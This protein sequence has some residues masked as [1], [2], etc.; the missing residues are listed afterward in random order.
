MTKISL[1][2]CLK[3]GIGLGFAGALG[4]T[5]LEALYLL[6]GPKRAFFNSPSEVILCLIFLVGLIPLWGV[7]IGLIEG[8]V[9]RLIFLIP[10]GKGRLNIPAL[11]LALLYSLTLFA[12]EIYRN[13][14][15]SG[16]SHP[17]K[18]HLYLQVL[19]LNILVCG[20]L[21][22]PLY[23]LQNGRYYLVG[24]TP[25]PLPRR[26]LSTLIRILFAAG[27]AAGIYLINASFFPRQ[28]PYIH[29]MFVL[30]AFWLFQL[31]LLKTFRKRYKSAGRIIQSTTAVLTVAALLIVFFSFEKNQ[32]ARRI[33]LLESPI[34]SKAVHWLQKPFDRD[35][36]GYSS[37]LGGGD[38]DDRDNRINPAAFDIPGNGIDEDCRGGDRSG[39]TPRPAA[40]GGETSGFDLDTAPNIVF[41][42]LD[43]A[44]A[45]NMSCYGYSRK[46]SPAIDSVAEDGILFTNALSPSSKTLFSM[47]AIMT[48]RYFDDTGYGPPPITLA[49]VLRKRGYRTAVFGPK[50]GFNPYP[51]TRFAFYRGFEVTELD[52]EPSRQEEDTLSEELTVKAIK[53]IER[54]RR[55]RF[56]IWLE[57]FDPHAPYFPNPKT[58][59]W[60]EH[61]ID[62]Y[63]GEIARSD[64]LAGQFLDE[65]KRLGLYNR[66]VLVIFSDNGEEFGEHGST[67]HATTLYQEQVH[68]PLII[69]GPG[70]EPG[71]VDEFVSLADLLPTVLDI[72]G[73]EPP[74]GAR[75]TSLLITESENTPPEPVF[76]ENP[77]HQVRKLAVLFYPWKLIFD[78]QFNTFE[79]YD[80]ENDPGELKNI[81]DE[82]PVETDRLKD[83]L[84]SHY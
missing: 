29:N 43:S 79:L 56:F 6:L 55:E 70:L 21:I 44:R 51:E 48:S 14:I 32:N 80:I 75:G 81:F 64:E 46:T 4:I 57:Y 45:D 20:G 71:R 10:R 83:L 78:Y 84:Y 39:H 42:H 67:S 77:K 15:I 23:L 9:S 52:R 72:L 8:V 63:D 74:E 34:A 2:G 68:V 47:N 69:R 35:R 40:A 36:D 59:E 53:F 65:L 49:E 11:V 25:S 37:I 60:G 19:G 58:E 28:Y 12:Y 7:V 61:P 66:T 17:A 26:N 1:G 16:L 30:A 31:A 33:I 54:H 13:G 38:C 82:H 50:I 3:T 62:R 73:I 27:A 24:G 5:I 76:L 18:G 41:I 22:F